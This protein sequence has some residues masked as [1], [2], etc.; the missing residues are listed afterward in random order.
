MA[1]CVEDLDL[2]AEQ[3]LG[4][5]WE[6]WMGGVESTLAHAKE[7]MWEGHPATGP[8]LGRNQKTWDQW[9]SVVIHLTEAFPGR[10]RLGEWD[11]FILCLLD[12]EWLVIKGSELE[13][14]Y[15]KER[16]SW[17]FRRALCRS[18]QRRD[19][20]SPYPRDNPGALRL[21]EG[22][23]LVDSHPTAGSEGDGRV[24]RP[25]TRART[26]GMDG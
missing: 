2:Q 21:W 9:R 25:R 1:D 23:T 8:V 5:K 24:Y 16:I 17:F 10:S 19:R 14:F 15:W 22:W 6:E 12:E 26:P 7:E 18:E 20:G 13:K 3:G 4:Y 11:A